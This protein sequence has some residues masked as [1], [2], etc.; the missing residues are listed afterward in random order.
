MDIPDAL[1]KHY[2]LAVTD[3]ELRVTRCFETSNVSIANRA[4]Y[5]RNK[6]EA[7][8]RLRFRGCLLDVAR[9]WFLQEINDRELQF[10]NLRSHTLEKNKTFQKGTNL[11]DSKFWVEWYQKKVKDASDQAYSLLTLAAALHPTVVSVSLKV[12]DRLN[13]LWPSAPAPNATTTETGSHD[14]LRVRLKRTRRMGSSQLS[15]LIG[16]KEDD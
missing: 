3:V 2:G 7:Y 12:N 13:T 4:C 16:G 14:T 10:W 1:A 15:R 6:G 5:I 9:T 8:T 11:E